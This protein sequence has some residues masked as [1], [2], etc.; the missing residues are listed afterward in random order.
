MQPGGAGR[1]RKAAVGGYG[2]RYS[3]NAAPVGIDM[4]IERRPSKRCQT[5]G[6]LLRAPGAGKLQSFAQA[7]PHDVCFRPEHDVIN[8]M[9]LRGQPPDDLV[10][11]RGIGQRHRHKDDAGTVIQLVQQIMIDLWPQGLVLE[12][13]V[14]SFFRRASPQPLPGQLWIVNKR[15]W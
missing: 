15:A 9:P 5:C 1:E 8:L 7:L 11:I 2:F 10:I 13:G 6:K 3:G 4:G 14:L 12:V